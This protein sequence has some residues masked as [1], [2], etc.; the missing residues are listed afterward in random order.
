M[1]TATV[2]RDASTAGAGGEDTAFSSLTSVGGA[3]A[4]AGVL[5]PLAGDPARRD[6]GDGPRRPDIGACLLSILFFVGVSAL[7][8]RIIQS[9]SAR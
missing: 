2:T 1:R 8:F 9:F 6:I 3:S 5:A 7:A 4:G